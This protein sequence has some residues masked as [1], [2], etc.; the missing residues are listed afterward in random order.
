MSANKIE[1]GEEKSVGVAEDASCGIAAVDN[2]KLEECDGCDLVKDC[3][4]E[5]REDHREQH[6]EECENRAK[7]LHD[8]ELFTQPDSC[9]FGECPIC[10]LPMPLE[11][12]KS[13][14]YS[15]CSK[16]I[17]KGCGHANDISTKQRS[18]PFCREPVVDAKE[19]VKRV[20][21][22]VKA[23]DPVATLEMGTT[24]Y[25]EGDFDGAFEYLTKA[26][27]LGDMTAHNELGI[28]YARGEGVEKDE[29]KAVYLLEMAA[30]VGHPDARYNLGFIEERNGNM[31]RA[32]KHWIIAAKLGDTGSMK[33]L[34]RH[35]SKGNIT[36]DDLEATL[37]AHQTA[38]D[39]MKSPQREAAAAAQHNKKPT[40]KVM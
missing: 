21:K 9:C 15:C 2:I 1:G 26:A 16:Q 20:M 33:A 19:N 31:E 12:Q 17:C 24:L 22:R 34:W 38:I 7:E 11:G 6:A 36:K 40:N 3:S 13:I 27:E 18:C 8:K 30:I 10:F 32:V 39:A 14:F 37:R 29:E 28:M 5:C 25:H 35:Y 4:N 23:N